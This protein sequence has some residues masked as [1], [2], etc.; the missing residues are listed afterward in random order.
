MAKYK[1]YLHTNKTNGKVYVGITKQAV[2]RRW[3]NGHGYAGTFFGNAIAKYGWDGFTHEVWFTGLRKEDACSMEQAMIL[4]F[5]SNER[6]HGYNISEGGQTCDCVNIRVGADN[7]KSRAVIRINPATNEKVRFVTMRAAAK[8]IGGNYKGIVKACRGQRNTYLGYVWEYA[9][10]A[11][12]KPPKRVQDWAAIAKK[13][14]KPVKMTDTDGTVRIF[15]SVKEAGAYIG[16]KSW[17]VSRYLL[18][19]RKDSSGRV[20][21]YADR[22]TYAKAD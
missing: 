1:V 2:E 8:E 13:H 16:R 15:E 18:N 9:D 17:T 11:F 20:W 6:E 21:E 19:Q 5:H 7:P 4:Y 3:Q 14:E 22:C 10:V 12:E